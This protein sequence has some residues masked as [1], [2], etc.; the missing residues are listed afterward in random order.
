MIDPDGIERYTGDFE[1]LEKDISGL[2]SDAT[3]IRSGG[4]DVHSRFQMLGAY[5]VAPEAEDLFATTQPVMDKADVFAGHLETV[6]DALETFVA[7]ARPL[8]QRLENLR[9]DALKFVESVKGDD[10]WTYDGDKTDRQ[11]EIS[12]S[13]AAAAVALKAAERRAATKISALVHGPKFIEDDGS[14]KQTKKEVMYGYDL[15]AYEHAEKLP[16]G[17]VESKSHHPWD[18]GYYGKQLWDGYVIDGAWAGVKGLGHLVGIGGSAKEAWGGIGNALSGIGQYTAMPY[19]WVMDKTIGPGDG[20]PDNEQKKA[21][22]EFLKGMVAWDQWE[23]NPTRATGTVA[24]NFGTI[25]LGPALKALANSSKGGAAAKA[26]G[27]AAKVIPYTDP[28]YA[29]LAAGG[30]AFSKLPKVSD[31]AGRI[32]VGATAEAQ[33]AHSVLEF[34]GA[35]VRIEDG[36]FIRVDAEGNPIKDTAPHEKSADERATSEHAHAPSQREP[37]F[38]G[39]GVRT[40]EGTATAGENLPPQASHGTAA[41]GTAGDA[42]GGFA[43]G[44]SAAHDPLPAGSGQG[45]HSPDTPVGGGS[46]RSGHQPLAGEGSHGGSPHGTSHGPP[47]AGNGGSDMPSAEAAE[48][49][50]ADSD[51]GA[52]HELPRGDERF[53]EGPHTAG[54]PAGPMPPD[55]EAAVTA[56]LD[57][58]KMPAQDQQRLLTQLRKN[59]H[60]A[61]VAEYIARGD[62]DG[63]PG[64]RR[65][66]F[67]AKQKGMIPAVHQAMEYASELRSRGVRDLAFE[68]KLPEQGLDLDV[69]VK[70]GDEIKF[71]VQLKVVEGEQSIKSAARKIAEKQLAGDIAG[72]KVAILD[73]P[74]VKG[75]LT[76]VTIRKVEHFAGKTGATFELRFEDGSVTIPPNGQIYP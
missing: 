2:R 32:R 63:V 3:G 26:A 59:G 69:L 5:Y 30:K 65:M 39:A 72:P 15:E 70:S 11:R 41:G 12:D 19:E 13:V 8:A 37:A 34:D 1:Q 9:E 38:A 53:T 74:D 66:V 21:A 44:P 28:V 56:A 29:G 40:P 35:R 64:Y 58:L 48:P 57:R 46:A 33:G 60:G 45:G 31:L 43:H 51:A 25:G 54:K 10:D 47:R 6:A 17:T 61:E 24:F 27:T 23:K 7:E 50:W 4:A 18:L 73:V 55:R 42:S 14:H 16:W 62:F 75:A 49:G 67:D 22:R 52:G 20:L 36:K 76:D 71:G 68:E